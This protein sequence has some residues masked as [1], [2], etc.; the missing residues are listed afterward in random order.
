MSAMMTLPDGDGLTLIKTIR[1][2]RGGLPILTF[3]LWYH[4]TARPAPAELSFLLSMTRS[5]RSG[6]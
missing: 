5:G 2:I 4:V 1:R 3:R 6:L